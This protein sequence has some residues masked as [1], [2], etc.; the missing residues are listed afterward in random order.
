MDEQPPVTIT[1]H[2]AGRT[3]TGS[4]M[5]ISAGESRILIDCGLFQGSRSLEALNY[6]AFAFDLKKIDA[7]LLTHAHIDH[8]GLLPR[9][10]AAGYDGPVWCTPQTR[11]LLDVVL[12]DAG[13]LQ[14]SDTARRNRRADRASELPLQPIYTGNDGERA[15]RLARGMALR[16]W[17]E[18]A[19]GIQARLWNA[20]HIL[21]SASIELSIG[22]LRL[23]FSGDL[24]PENK[25]FYPDPEAPAGFDHVVCESTYGDRTFAQPTIRQ[26][27]TLLQQEIKLALARGG[28]LVVPVFALERTQ[29]LLLDIASLINAG[30]IARVPVYIDSP[31]AGQATRIFAS[32]ADALEDLGRG[33][34]FDHPA[35]HFVE[36]A[37]KSMALNDV[38]GAIILAASGMCEGGRIRHHLRHNLPR[39]DSTILFVGF[40]SAGT[41]GRAI[42]EG[43]RRVRMWG[44]TIPVRASIRRLESY[45]AHADRDG[46]IAWLADRAPIEGSLFLTHGEADAVDMLSAEITERSLAQSI[47]V[48]QMGECYAL[49]P[50]VKANLEG[51]ANP[52]ASAATG[53]DW[54]NSC[55]DLLAN[56][57]AELRK[58]PTAHGREMALRRMSEAL[59]SSVLE[60]STPTTD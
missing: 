1:F 23:L 36:T 9:L 6:R 25:A 34:I 5:E 2:G 43:A 29:E 39:P 13:R 24:G 21:G 40:Q 32:H 57:Q 27:R 41:L 8:C 31:L 22:D 19:P 56:L 47:I 3:V 59:T 45:A 14:E 4:C 52:E 7:V 55:A 51:A 37:D 30:R 20:A 35:F 16:Q 18:P 28:N 44:R 54:R 50:G 33:R 38:S 26:R 53:S 15:V 48:P 42:L 10:V 11:D 60:K 58:I 49:A 17:F 12:P 46:L